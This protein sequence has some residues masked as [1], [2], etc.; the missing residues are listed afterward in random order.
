MQELLLTP[1]TGNNSLSPEGTLSSRRKVLSLNRPS[2]FSRVSKTR[3]AVTVK[4]ASNEQSSLAR[5][6]ALSLYCRALLRLY[7][8]DTGGSERGKGVDIL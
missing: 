7:R 8:C 4:L 3:L 1:Y 2:E 5:D 6:K